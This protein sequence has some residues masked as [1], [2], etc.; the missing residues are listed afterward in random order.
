[1]TVSIK[2]REQTKRRLERLGADIASKAGKDL[3]TQ[4]LLDALVEVGEDDPAR[5]AG[6]VSRVKLPLSAAAQKRVLSF[7]F[8]WGVRDTEKDINLA[9]YSD[10]AIHGGRKAPG[11]KRR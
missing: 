7:A 3:S 5:V 11:R 8:D 2:I 4:D 10:E 9:L 6:A 1:M